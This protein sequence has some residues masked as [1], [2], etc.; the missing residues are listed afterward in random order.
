MVSCYH[1]VSIGLVGVVRV[2]RRRHAAELLPRDEFL[3]A[4]HAADVLAGNSSCGL[5][6]ACYTGTPVLHAGERNRGR[7]HGENVIF[8]PL[9]IEAI[10]EGLERALAREF[11]DRARKAPCPWG[12][13]TAGERIARILAKVP[14]G[15]EILAKRLVL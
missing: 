7:E 1:P 11:R 3:Q 4:L 2:E 9:D 13:G 14:L 8:V 5:I 15:P 12:D 6:E 10:E